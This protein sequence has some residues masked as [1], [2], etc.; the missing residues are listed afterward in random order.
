VQRVSRPA[1]HRAEDARRGPCRS[2]AGRRGPRE[3]RREGAPGDEV[4]RTR[5]KYGQHFL[6]PVWANKVVEVIAPQPDDRF[7]E[8]G[9]GAGALTIPLASRVAELTAIEVDPQMVATLR[10]RV[11]TNVRIVQADFLDVDLRSLL[12]PTGVRIAGNLPYNVSSPILFTLL[13][14]HKRNAAFIDATVMLQREVADRIQARPGTRDYGV[15]SILIQLHADVR[16]RLSLPPGAFR[17]QPKV[18]SA[19]LS[20]RFR[21]P[22]VDVVDEAV[23][24]SMVKSMFTQRRKMLTNALASFSAARNR[25]TVDALRDA[26]I[27]SRRRPET[28]QLEELARLAAVFAAI[29]R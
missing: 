14:A 9:S 10:R 5:K 26:S 27:D 3:R 13:D 16:L 23:F 29:T 12:P 28:L 25:N 1:P 20:L 11:P 24:E 21:A 19:V 15:L 8:I 17:P 6:E 4:P 7:L 2:R 22:A 18:H